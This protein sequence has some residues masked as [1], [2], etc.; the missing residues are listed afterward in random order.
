MNNLSEF[1]NT[2][3]KLMNNEEQLIRNYNHLTGKFDSTNKKRIKD[4]LII[5]GLHSLYFNDLNKKFDLNV[6]LDLEEEIKKETKVFR[7]TERGKKK[8]SILKEID[9]RKKDFNKYILPQ[10]NF[11]DIYIKTLYR[12]IDKV[13]F[14]IHFKNDYF[15]EF[16][17]FFSGLNEINI[18]N[19]QQEPGLTIF[20]LDV[21]NHS[22]SKFFK[23][24]TKDIANLKNNKFNESKIEKPENFELFCKLALVL[25]MLNKKMENN[26]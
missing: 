10:K 26:L 16:K 1:K 12:G 8:E 7:D 19:A 4:F 13:K 5:E 18:S 21:D 20:E 17:N 23:L 6:F 3:I 9:K 15:F 24:L 2:V 25:F 14:K 11:S 22:S